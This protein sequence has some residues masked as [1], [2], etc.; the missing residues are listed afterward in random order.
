VISKTSAHVH[1]TRACYHFD[2]ILRVIILI[3][4]CVLSFW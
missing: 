2:M 3:G 1:I 4:Y